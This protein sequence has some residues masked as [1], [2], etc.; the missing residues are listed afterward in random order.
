MIPVAAAGLEDMDVLLKGKNII[1]YGGA[2]AIGGA[3]ARAFAREGARVHL[4]GRTLSSLEAVAADIRSAGG[5]AETA[6]VDALDERAVDEHV[7]GVVARTGSLDVS[8]NVMSHGDVRGR[9]SPRWRWTTSCGR[10]CDRHSDDV[11]DGASGGAA[12]D[13]AALGRD[14]A[15]RR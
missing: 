4:A 10:W 11:P 8:M 9:R 2:G 1:V 6:V 15:V 12:D 7:D 3:V 14:P 5:R 13:P